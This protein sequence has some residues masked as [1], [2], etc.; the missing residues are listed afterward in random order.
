[1]RREKNSMAKDK[2]SVLDDIFAN[3]PMGL[4]E[5]KPQR[6]KAQSSDERLINSFEEINVFFDSKKR[7]PEASTADINEYQLYSRLKGINESTDKINLLR[8]YDRHQLLKISVDVIA[9]DQ[10]N[11]KASKEIDS[12]DDLLES[13]DIGLLSEKDDIFDFNNVPKDY[14]RA[15]SDFIAK[16]KPCPNFSEYEP[17]FKQV[18]KDLLDGNRKILKFR[19]GN[20]KEENFYIHNGVM[21]LLVKINIE[22]QEHYKPDGTRVRE[23]G[24]T[25]CI[26]ENGTQSNMLKRSVEK[27][28]YENGQTI[29]AHKDEGVKKLERELENITEED[30]STG[31]I[32]VLKSK[33]ANPEIRN[34]EDLYKIGFSK[35]KTQKRIQDA[36]KQ[37]TYLMSD[38]ELVSEWQCFNMNPQ[39]FEKLIHQVFGHTCLDI[40]VKDSRGKE[41]K[42]REWFIVP[43]H[44]IEDAVD[45]IISGE[46]VD[47]KF[48]NL[49][50][51]IE[52]I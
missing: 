7:V 48:N 3:D 28:L 40:S 4:L 15:S 26:F 29:S 52:K 41:H 50:Q 16:R 19:Q 23:D 34:I 24:R 35:N 43:I 20:L 18:H 30:S 5:V 36:E 6:S 11:Y 38:V 44:V 46:I 17:L 45:K 31:Y 22:Q 47:Y 14:Q 21:F 37:A 2:D 27:I 49:T 8:E 12:I 10:S 42:P 25:L 13:D 51:C 1:M 9:E 33:S 39:K 32:Y